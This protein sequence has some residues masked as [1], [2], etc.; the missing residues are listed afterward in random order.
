MDLFQSIKPLWPIIPSILFILLLNFLI[1]YYSNYI[2]GKGGEWR[3]K[4]RLNELDPKQYKILNDIMLPSNGN[5]NTTQ[6]DHIVVS[7]HGIFCIETKAYRGKIYGN[8]FQEK[9]TQYLSG[10][11]YPFYNPIRQNYAHIKS[12]ENLIKPIFPAVSVFGFVVFPDVDKLN[13]SGAD[14]V[15]MYAKDLMKKIRDVNLQSLTDDGV[16][17][18]VE[19]LS[20]ANITDG[21]V[22]KQHDTDT[23]NLLG[24]S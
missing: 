24:R 15:F 16:M 6:I 7:N 19:M 3:V 20:K 17:S 2:K 13:I 10:K 11:K 4:N 21:N 22:R 9:W 8:A 14:N 12:V 18:A 5:T 23:N 1:E